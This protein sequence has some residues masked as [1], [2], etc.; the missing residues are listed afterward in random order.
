MVDI[1]R[2]LRGGSLRA[3]LAL[4]ILLAL[5]PAA[6]LVFLSDL[7]ARREDRQDAE[8][9]ARQLVRLEAAAVGHLLEGSRHLT[10][11]LAELGQSSSAAEPLD[12]LLLR[13]LERNPDYTNLAILDDRGEVLASAIPPPDTSSMAAQAFFAEVLRRGEF[14]VGGFT[15]GLISHRPILNLAQPILDDRGRVRQVA[16]ASLSLDALQKALLEARLPP[17]SQIILLDRDGRTLAAYPGGARQIGRSL[18][19]TPLGRLM[20]KEDDGFVEMAGVDGV[21]RLN[22]FSQVPGSGGALRLGIGLD[23]D[24]IYAA[25]DQRRARNFFWLSLVTLG[26]IITAYLA[27]NSLLLRRLRILSL[28]A[29][30]ISTGDLGARAEVQGRDEIANVAEAFNQMARRLSEMMASGEQTRFRLTE[31]VSRLVK[32]RTRE[33]E[34]LNRLGE[35]LQACNS[36]TEAYDV[37]ARHMRRLF[38]HGGGAVGIISASRNLVEIIAQWGDPTAHERDFRPEECW[39]LR[40]GRQS[41]V[42]ENSDGAACEHAPR[43]A[44]RGTLCTP[45]VALGETIGVLYLWEPNRSTVVPAPPDDEAQ[46]LAI[47]DDAP[48]GIAARRLQAQNVAERIAIALANLQLQET[49][50]SQSIRDPLTGLFNRRY[51]EESVDREVRRAQRSHG[52]VAFIMVDVDHFKRYNDDHGH[53]AGDVVLREIG[54]LLKANLRGGDIACRFGGEE[55]VLILADT[56]AEVARHRAEQMRLAA[57]RL[58]LTH[59]GETLPPVTISLGVA[60]FPDQGDTREAL[61]QAADEALYAAKNGGR[62]RVVVAEG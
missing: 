17:S 21:P 62:N 41:L 47:A 4:I 31:H 6:A 26:A 7:E 54:G 55:F 24:E 19:D 36:A 57:A 32:E 59:R 9:R 42:D 30:R 44:T 50:R 58:R 45:L 27:G 29:D 40:L 15:I 49:L 43:N 60:V 2:R 48:T 34:L 35:M 56:G 14:V 10:G 38:P 61:L 1:I 39:A 28:T 23:R 46:L 37:L 13:L 51:M 5:A 3:N 20:M 12:R 16:V 25:T 8:Q 52:S 18:A 11:W 33:L 22:A 53:E